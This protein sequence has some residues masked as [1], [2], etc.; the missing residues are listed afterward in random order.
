MFPQL[1]QPLGDSD[2]CGMPCLVVRVSRCVATYLQ[3]LGQIIY[4]ASFQ[5]LD[6]LKRDYINFWFCCSGFMLQDNCK[7]QG[8]GDEI[9][10]HQ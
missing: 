8:L 1:T 4:I 10:K 9:I 2:A 6:Y 3:S 5:E 7:S